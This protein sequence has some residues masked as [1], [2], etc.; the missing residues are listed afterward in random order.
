MHRNSRKSA[1]D[2]PELFVR[3]SLSD[4]Y[5]AHSFEDSHYLAWLENWH[6]AH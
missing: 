6:V 4:L 2:V 1:I 3:T 5:K